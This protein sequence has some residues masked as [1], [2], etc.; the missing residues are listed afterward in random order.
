MQYITS[1]CDSSC[2]AKLG[3]VMSRQLAGNPGCVISSM[4]IKTG[5]RG[6]QLPRLLL[7]RSALLNR[8]LPGSWQT[9][10]TSGPASGTLASSL[11]L[12]RIP[13]L[14]HINLFKAP[15][16]NQP[17]ATMKTNVAL[18]ALVASLLTIAA[19]RQLL[20]SGTARVT[21]FDNGNYSGGGQA[22]STDVPATGCGSCENL[23]RSTQYRPIRTSPT[24]RPIL[25]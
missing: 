15:R 22:F 14:R 3:N 7:H 13:V 18:V 1:K 24:S 20:Q 25:C 10:G 19:G 11:D 9:Q 2:S 23:V 16:R 4:K 5:R 8:Q 17:T 6:L 12:S 21:F